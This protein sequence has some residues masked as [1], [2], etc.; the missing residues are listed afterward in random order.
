MSGRDNRAGHQSGQC[1]QGPVTVKG[2]LQ[3]QM[4]IRKLPRSCLVT[5]LG[6]GWPWGSGLSVCENELNES[7]V[8]LDRR[9]YTRY[10]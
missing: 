8:W 1:Y 10:L 9:A 6:H 4:G 2:S 3:G 7:R 5:T